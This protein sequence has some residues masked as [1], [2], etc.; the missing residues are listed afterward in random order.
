MRRLQDQEKEEAKRDKLE[1]KADKIERKLDAIQKKVE[2]AE[3]K[4][5][6]L[7]TKQ[8]ALEKKLEK[9]E[10]KLDK[11]EKKKDEKKK[12]EKKKP[13]LRGLPLRISAPGEQLALA[14]SLYKD[15]LAADRGSQSIIRRLAAR[16]PMRVRFPDKQEKILDGDEA[17]LD[18]AEK[19]ADKDEKDL[20]QLEKNLEKLEE[21]WDKLEKEL[22]KQEKDADED[23]KELD[24]EKPKKKA[25]KTLTL[26]DQRGPLAPRSYGTYGTSY[27]IRSLIATLRAGGPGARQAARRLEQ[28]G[29]AA[30]VALC[31]AYDSPVEHFRWEIVNLLGYTKDPR[32]IPLLAR[33]GIHDPEVHPRWRSIWALTSVDDGSVPGLLRAQ[34]ARSRGLRRRHAAVALSLYQ[35]P[36]AL[37]VLREGLRD[38]DPWIR[39]ESASCL[40]SYADLHAAREIMRLYEREEDP[41]IR[42]EMIRALGGISNPSVTAFLKRRLAELDPHLRLTVVYALST[43]PAARRSRAV[44]RAHLT[45]ERNRSVRKAIREELAAAS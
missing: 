10:A 30:T 19:A 1:K 45:R 18:K 40:A 33:R 26:E 16:G 24:G 43:P 41:S 39:W 4:A 32:A 9:L 20:D 31:R 35:D 3:G 17:D 15:G 27:T 6:A 7:E 21:I 29:S 13:R 5:D 8:D 37:P 11:L 2:K 14:V 22:D 44:L 12:G 23:E 38:P 42:R 34:I 25:R 36:A 28:I